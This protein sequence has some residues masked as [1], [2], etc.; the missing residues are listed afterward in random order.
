MFLGS[1]H[2]SSCTRTRPSPGGFWGRFG[3]FL[4]VLRLVLGF[5]GIPEMVF[6]VFLESYRSSSCRWTRPG[7]GGCSRAGRGWISC[8]GGKATSGNRCLPQNQPEMAQNQ[9][10][11]IR[12]PPNLI[13]NHPR[14]SSNLPD[15]PKT[16]PKTLKKNPSIDKKTASKSHPNWLRDPPNAPNPTQRC[17]RTLGTPQ[18]HKET[19]GNP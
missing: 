9:P 11:S 3:G 7:P 12:D 18:K 16:Q 6:G 2:S 14:D 19:S 8:V 17:H 13:Q 1:D 15:L 10:K 5:L 4:G